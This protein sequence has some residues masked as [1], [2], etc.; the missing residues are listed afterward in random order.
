[1]HT[2]ATFL[3]GMAVGYVLGARAGRERYEQI[4]R[5]AQVIWQNPT[6]QQKVGDVEG[7]AAETAKSTGHQ[8]QEKAGSAAHSLL[9]TAKHKVAEVKEHRAPAGSRPA[10]TP[11]YESTEL[12]GSRAQAGSNGRVD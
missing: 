12:P 2:R 9:D 6:V 4:R 11:T 7:K 3:S 5:A 1:M 10:T 8:L